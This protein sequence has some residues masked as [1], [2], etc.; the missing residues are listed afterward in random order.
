MQAKAVMMAWRSRGRGWAFNNH[1]TI[2]SN[3]IM[4][5]G[6]VAHVMIVVMP[7]HLPKLQ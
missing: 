3:P 6:R 4:H 5:V 2:M 1:H 7:F